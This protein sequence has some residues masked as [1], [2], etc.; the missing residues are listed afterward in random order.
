[1]QDCRLELALDTSAYIPRSVL[2][3]IMADALALRRMYP[4]M[5]RS[6]ADGA[7]LPSSTRR[8]MSAPLYS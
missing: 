2:F 6:C 8:Q 5:R 7:S 3:T 1:M 4:A